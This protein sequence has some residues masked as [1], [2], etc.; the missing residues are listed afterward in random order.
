[1]TAAPDPRI[2]RAYAALRFVVDPELG[3]DIVELGLVYDIRVEDGTLVAEITLTTPGCPVTES[4][5]AEAGAV[6]ADTLGAPVRVEV[7]WDP[8][9]TP[10]MISPA[11]AAALGFGRR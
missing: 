2:D 6:L 7:V 11:A 5:P 8:P 1:M 3:L 9:W 10:E 4:L